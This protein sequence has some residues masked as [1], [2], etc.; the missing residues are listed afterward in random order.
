VLSVHKELD[1]SVARSVSS[2]ALALQRGRVPAA[3]RLSRTVF[4]GHKAGSTFAMYASQSNSFSVN[5]SFSSHRGCTPNHQ[6]TGKHGESQ[7]MPL[8]EE[9]RHW[10]MRSHCQSW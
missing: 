8:N 7:G 2:T 6:E 9:Q 10:R 3:A 5:A 4:Q 1:L